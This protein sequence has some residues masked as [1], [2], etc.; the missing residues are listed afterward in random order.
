MC[1][2]CVAVFC[3]ARGLGFA[4]PT[5]QLPIWR[6]VPSALP[7]VSP[8][9]WQAIGVSEA[10]WLSLTHPCTPCAR[11]VGP[12]LPHQQNLLGGGRGII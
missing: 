6:K 10:K 9:Y 12:L 2:D 1:C 5:R 11:H 3:A 7:K 8:P 4:V